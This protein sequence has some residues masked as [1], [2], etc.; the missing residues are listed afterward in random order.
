[1]NIDLSK[2]TRV[3]VLGVALTVAAGC[4]SAGEQDAAGNAAPREEVREQQAEGEAQPIGEEKLA[5]VQADEM[6]AEEM[7]AVAPE[8]SLEG[9]APAPPGPA[10]A[11]G[12][13]PDRAPSGRT[14]SLA[15]APRSADVSAADDSSEGRDLPPR[16]PR[17]PEPREYQERERRPEPPPAAMYFQDYGVNPWEDV[18]DDNLSTFAM[19]VDTGSYTVARNYL[20]DGHLPPVDAVRA[21]EFVNYFEQGYEPPRRGAFAIHVDGAPSPFGEEGEKLLRVCI[22]AREVKES[23]RKD[24]VLTFVV[25]VSGSMDQDDRLE[26][27]KDALNM[28]V[29][30][31]RPEDQVSI[32]AYSDDAWVVLEPTSADERRRIRAAIRELYPTDSTNA[33]A[34]LELGY[35]LAEEAFRRDAINRVILCSDGVANVGATGPDQI[36]RRIGRSVD[37]G[38]TLTSI[39]V[40]MGNYNDVLLERLADEGD[41]AYFYVDDLDE[42]EKVFVENLTGTLQLVAR[43]AK[44]QVEFNPDVVDYYR[45]IGYENREVRDRDFRN[46]RVDAGEVGSGDSVTALY[47]VHL[48]RRADGEIATVRV[49]YEDPDGGKVRELDRTFHTDDLERSFDDADARFRLTASAAAFAEILRDSY[50]NRLTTLDEVIAV[51]EEAADDLRRD[52]EADELVDLM[53]RADRLR[54]SYTGGR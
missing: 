21:E 42:A 32:V 38:I 26:L 46:D 11:G 54:P 41:G 33:E 45:L 30:E 19:D 47:A 22:Q 43:D 39:G 36:L 20:G 44:A 29:D 37:R 2:L 3:L 40:G 50:Y 8:R 1:M 17:H 9:A 10:G 16:E 13:M 27:V 5:D 34:G 28:L 48:R 52:D 35:E 6:P 25:D 12:A 15:L 49:R 51:A 23:G 18:F 7:R 4:A 31:L 24:A 53:M 14:D